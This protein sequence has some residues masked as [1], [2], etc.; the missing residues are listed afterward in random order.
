MGRA[1]IEQFRPDQPLIPGTPVS[2]SALVSLLMAAAGVVLLLI[3][4]GKI[5]PA[6]A[7]GWEEKY[8]LEAEEAKPETASA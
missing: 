1:I 3:R 7:Q 8:Q 2:Y 5:S 6:F 4:Y